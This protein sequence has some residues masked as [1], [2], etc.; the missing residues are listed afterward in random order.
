MSQ[1]PFRC[2]ADADHDAH[3]RRRA[4]VARQ[5]G[6]FLPGMV[7]GVEWNGAAFNPTTNTLFVGA[8]DWCANVQLAR[9]SIAIPHAGAAWFAAENQEHMLD[10]SDKAK[11]WVTAFD[12]DDGRVRWKYAAPHP[13][14]AGVTPTGGG[15]VFTAD[16]DGQLYAFDG[17][18]GRVL[19]QTNTGQSTG[20]GVITYAA[21]GRQLVAVAAGM[22]SPVWPGGADQSRIVVLGLP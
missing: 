18:S 19:W 6:A 22:K 15:L 3:Q 8:V 17:E 16:M 4:A 2:L 20:G 10:S 21:A 1:L 9:D 13:I 12:A 5:C 7:G 11:G 14:L